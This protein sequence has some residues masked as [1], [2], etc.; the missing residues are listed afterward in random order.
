VKKGGKRKLEGQVA[1]AE[2]LGPDVGKAEKKGSSNVRV[3]MGV[4]VMFE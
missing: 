2:L 3:S 4:I 1:S